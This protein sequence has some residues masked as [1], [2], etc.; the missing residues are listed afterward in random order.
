VIDVISYEIESMPNRG[1][2]SERGAAILRR[3]S[4][5][6]S[7]L[8]DSTLVLSR[9]CGA[10]LKHRIVVRSSPNKNERG[11][12]ALRPWVVLVASRSTD[13]LERASAAPMVAAGFCSSQCPAVSSRL[14]GRR[15]VC[16]RRRSGFAVA[17]ANVTLDNERESSCSVINFDAP[18]QHFALHQA[19]AVVNDAGLNTM[20]I[21]ISTDDT[22]ELV[23]SEFLVTNGNGKLAEVDFEPIRSHLS[24]LSESKTA[25]DAS[26]MDAE[27][28]E[29]QFVEEVPISEDDMVSSLLCSSLVLGLYGSL[30]SW[31]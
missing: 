22:Q 1:R 17:S 26:E 7:R 25:V 12:I 23:K 8:L 11:D 18:G 19:I 27:S 6:L 14:P 29:Y 2:S 28:T 24:A 15:N 21:S 16:S 13:I 30:C 9:I 3:T 20:R 31:L 10:F 5:Q 4:F